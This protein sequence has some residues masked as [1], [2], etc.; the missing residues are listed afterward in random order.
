M[1]VIKPADDKSHVSFKSTE[2]HAREK[3][4]FF[5][6]IY[7]SFIANYKAMNSCYEW[8]KH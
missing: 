4:K 1:T 8:R 2:I 7:A 3:K 6:K 5:I